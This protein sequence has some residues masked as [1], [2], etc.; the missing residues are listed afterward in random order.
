[1]QVCV[2]VCFGGCHL[3]VCCS[4]GVFLADNAARSARL[5]LLPFT[6]SLYSC[7][8]NETFKVASLCAC[9][10]VQRAY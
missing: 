10:C 8:V 5:S 7:E 4:F 6:L 3:F 9:V 1:M 2:C